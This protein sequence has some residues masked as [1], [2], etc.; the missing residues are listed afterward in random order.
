MPSDS[1]IPQE[2]KLTSG[3]RGL[4]RN[5]GIG[6]AALGMATAGF[7]RRADAETAIT[8]EDILNFALNLEYLE[9]EYYLHAV[10]GT[11]LPYADIT[12]TGTLGPV[13]GGSQVTFTNKYIYDYA[14]EIANDELNHV[15][16]LRSALGSA[17][18]AR[19]PIAL[20]TSFITLGHAS[21]VTPIGTKFD[22][23]ANEEM[24]L[25]GSYVFEDVG[26][27][28]YSGAAAS[29]TSKAYLTAAAGI[30]A[31][32]AYHASA[33]RLLIFQTSEALAEMADK[34]SAL[35]ADLSGVAD[36]QGPLGPNDVP[37][38]V[39]TDANSLAFTRTP[40]QVLNIVYGGGSANN[41]LFFPDKMNGTIS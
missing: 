34:V 3:R 2:T 11:G 19:P 41:Y 39:P 38:I 12:G 33:V 21:G 4:L 7:T 30:L 15:K 14:R 36:D 17:A 23:F 26:V 18:V 40:T 24:F 31:V 32:E 16:F 10:Y 20:D 8:D 22:P 1:I 13:G 25:L 6:A 29:I 37:N 28:A 9:A 27:T 5:V 35:R